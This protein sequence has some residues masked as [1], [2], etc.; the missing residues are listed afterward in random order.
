MLLNVYQWLPGAEQQRRDGLQTVWALF[1][2]WLKCSK[3]L[4]LQ[5]DFHRGIYPSQFKIHVHLK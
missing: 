5:G 3:Y 4:V 2:G 1:A